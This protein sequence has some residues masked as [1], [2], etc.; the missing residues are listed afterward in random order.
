M[1]CGVTWIVA[2]LG[3]EIQHPSILLRWRL[4]LC[5]PSG[6]FAVVFLCSWCVIISVPLCVDAAGSLASVSSPVSSMA[7]ASA[8]SSSSM[9]VASTSRPSAVSSH[10]LVH[11]NSDCMGEFEKIEEYLGLT[12]RW[13][14]QCPDCDAEHD[15][16][17][18]AS[19]RPSHASSSRCV[20]E[21]VCSSCL[22]A[23]DP[24]NAPSPRL[25]PRRALVYVCLFVV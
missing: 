10:D 21:F 6:S 1:L 16:E 7:H 2:I 22:F 17:H 5:T 3:S 18:D 15:V 14:W 12:R 20:C 19:S 8:S 9:A 4:L 25:S 24:I 13:V 11:A 23:I